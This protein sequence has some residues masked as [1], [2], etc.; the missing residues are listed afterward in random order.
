MHKKYNDDSSKCKNFY[1]NL[2]EGFKICPYGFTYYKN[3]L[4][5]SGYKVLENFNEKKI[6][7]HEKNSKIK[8]PMT[9]YTVDDF[10]E[11]VVSDERDVKYAQLKETH[12]I[13]TNTI[14]DI[15]RAISS[16]RDVLEEIDFENEEKTIKDGYDLINTRLD[17]HDRILMKDNATKIFGKIKPHKIIKK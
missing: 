15:K 1:S 16:I 10:I 14:H 8:F 6:N 7:G 17:Y 12:D 4:I 11:H 9:I 5:Y 2:E 13:C 3:N